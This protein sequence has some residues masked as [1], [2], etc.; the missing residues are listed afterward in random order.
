MIEGASLLSILFII[1]RLRERNLR[2]RAAEL[3]QKVQ[4]KTHQILE[5][6][7]EVDE[8]K[9]R[10]YTNIS[11][12]FRTPLTLLINPIEDAMKQEQEK[13]EVSKRILSTMHRNARRLQNL[14]N[15]LL[16]ISRI[17]SGTLK[18]KI[19]EFLLNVQLEKILEYNNDLKDQHAKENL[20]IKIKVPEGTDKLF[21]KTDQ[22]IL[23]QIYVRT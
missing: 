19:S 4:E 7:K 11:H 3:E 10:F 23:Q 21:V 18:P 8:M 17:E 2:I 9:S 20:V 22:M 6:R 15:Q 13:T 5:Q 14:I 16:D 12:E 1:I